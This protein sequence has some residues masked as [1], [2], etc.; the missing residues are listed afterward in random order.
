MLFSPHLSKS[1]FKSPQIDTLEQKGRG[2]SLETGASPPSLA[3]CGNMGKLSK[4]CF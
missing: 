2:C 4:M 1:S 3:A